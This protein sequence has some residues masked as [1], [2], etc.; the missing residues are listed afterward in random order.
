[1]IISTETASVSKLVGEEKA[2]EL[3]ARAGFDAW[4]FSIYPMCTYDKEKRIFLDNDHPLVKPDYLNFAKKLRRIGEYNGIFCNQSHAPFPLVMPS[5]DKYLKRSIECTSEAGGKIC[6]IHPYNYYTA[7][8]NAEIYFPLLEFAKDYGVKIAT[9]NMWGNWNEEENHATRAA[10]SD[11]K[12]F[13]AHL[14]AVNDDDFIACLDIGHAEMMGLNTSA[15]SMIKALGSKLQSLHIHD[16][17][18]RYDLHDIPFSGSID[19]EAVA[20]A[21]KEI[22]YMGEFTLEASG[23]IKKC[24]ADNVLNG[25]IELKKSVE[26]I[27]EMFEKA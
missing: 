6:V 26:K 22:G 20:K 24:N 10:C 3:I 19:F 5:I 14:D 1:M 13:L 27:A 8:E 15:V 2:V 25:L 23:Y 16:N 11:E 17:D 7:E 12:D 21:L 4:D 9:E 18:L